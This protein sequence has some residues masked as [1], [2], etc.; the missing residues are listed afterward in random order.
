MLCSALLAFCLG[1][2][3][4]A[5]PLRALTPALLLPQ[6]QHELKVFHNLYTQTAWYDAERRRT[7]AGERSTFFTTIGEWRTG[8]K[9]RW[10]AGL[11]AFF[12]SV[13][14]GTPDSS[15]LAVL[16]MGN[17]GQ[18]ARTA[19]T[20][21]GPTI[22][23]LPFGKSRTT[24]LKASLLFPLAADLQGLRTGQRYLEHDGY[25]LW[26]QWLYDRSLSD[27][28]QLYAEAGLW[29]RM[30][31][32][33]ELAN[34]YAVVPLKAF[35]SFLPNERF[36]A[37][38]FAEWS[39]VPTEPLR[40]Y[41]FQAGAGIKWYPVRRLELEVMSSLFAAGAQ[42]GAGWTANLGWRYLW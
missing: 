36:T 42:N 32:R 23:W 37:Y 3:A 27:T 34:S 41:Y 24:S 17:D 31:R 29:V 18:Q 38:A 9:A 7:P 22:R 30:D 15:P 21:A 12:R 25:Q 2:W 13:H 20:H 1:P 40:N 19:L 8:W 16:R 4:T 14:Y 10:N 35:L 6:G 28:W 39:G 26:L 33:F 5:Q 11:M